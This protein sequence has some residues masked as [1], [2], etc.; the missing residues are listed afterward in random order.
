MILLSVQRVI[1]KAE[2]KEWEQMSTSTQ[3]SSAVHNDS[4]DSWM[5]WTGTVVLVMGVADLVITCI[6][7]AEG[8]PVNESYGWAMALTTVFIVVFAGFFCKTN[9]EDQRKSWGAP[10]GK[11]ETAFMT[12]L[13]ISTVITGTT[14][15]L[16]LTVH[17]NFG[18]LGWVP[19][20]NLIL[21][22]I[23]PAVAYGV[24][25]ENQK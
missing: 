20:V 2:V 10:W 24:L 17:A 13:A 8:L 5:F 22:P 9:M 18:L 25:G 16:I 12:G 11:S 19:L 7:G 6:L 14:A 15:L 4:L 23:T 3:V 21:G 1:S